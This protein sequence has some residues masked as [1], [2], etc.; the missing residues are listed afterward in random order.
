MPRAYKTWMHQRLGSTVS[1][2][3]VEETLLT[4]EMDVLG[5]EPQGEMPAE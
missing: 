5:G 1:T 4:R 3:V 2:H